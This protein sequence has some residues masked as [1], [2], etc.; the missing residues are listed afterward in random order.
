MSTTFAQ[1]IAF[2]WLFVARHYQMAP[3]PLPICI[4]WLPAISQVATR[5]FQTFRPTLNIRPICYHLLSQRP[6]RSIQSSNRRSPPVTCYEAGCNVFP[7]TLLAGVGASVIS[8]LLVSSSARHWPTSTSGSI[9]PTNFF[10]SFVSIVPIVR[11]APHCLQ[12]RRGSAPIPHSCHRSRCPPG[13]S[14]QMA[15]HFLNFTSSATFLHDPPGS[16]LHYLPL[17]TVSFIFVL[18]VIGVRLLQLFISFRCIA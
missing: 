18:F 16:P 10:A 2:F 15:H 12:V 9:L 6:T 7:A 17:Q 1:L 8:R 13:S 11:V 3:S 14:H 4:Q 5:H